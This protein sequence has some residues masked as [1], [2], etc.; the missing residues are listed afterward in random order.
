M[1]RRSSQSGQGEK[2]KAQPPTAN[3][4]LP[5]SSL[6]RTRSPQEELVCRVALR[7]AVGELGA[8]KRG[9]GV[10][11]GT[12]VLG[13]KGA[14]EQ[15]GGGARERFQQNL[16]D[17]THQDGRQTTRPPGQKEGSS[18]IPPNG[19]P[20]RGFA[21]P[22]QEGAMDLGCHRPPSSTTRGIRRAPIKRPR[23]CRDSL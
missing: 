18:R 9:C 10:R 13:G 11:V 15:G 6:L 20:E 19:V 2:E 4:H 3:N 22:D 17:T 16:G 14:K 21:S 23:Y 5:P 1:K 7:K 8:A 12:R